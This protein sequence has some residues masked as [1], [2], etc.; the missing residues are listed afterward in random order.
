MIYD[1]IIL[2]G[3]PAGL[4]AAVYSARFKLNSLLIAKQIGGLLNEAHMVENWLGVKHAKGQELIKQFEEHVK[5]LKVPIKKEE[6]V[7]LKKKKNIFEVGTNKGKYQSKTIILALGTI[8][9]K[10]NVP[11]ED[12]YIGKGVSYCYICDAAFFKNKIVAV[13]GG[14]DSAVVA[15]LQLA[16]HAKQVYIIYR[17]DEIRAEPILK[18]KL[19]KNKK[20]KIITNTEITHIQGNNFVE[21]VIFNNG[22]EFKLD[23][24]FI[25]IGSVPSVDLAKEL[26]IKIDRNEQIIVDKAQ[27]TNIDGV[28]AAGDMTDSIMKQAITAAAEGSIAAMS[29]YRLI[30]G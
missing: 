26:S 16:E 1:V 11:G 14:N 18:H 17:K 9:R 12:K 8:K 21:K 25:E 3:G 13:I 5:A 6:V 23:G 2:G 10:L 28:F 4:G 15:A 20:I 27:K 30:K 7:S 29:A 24:I 22:R 19:A